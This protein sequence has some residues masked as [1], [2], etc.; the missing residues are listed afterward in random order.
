MAQPYEGDSSQQNQPGILGRNSADGVGVNGESDGGRGVAGF[1]KTWQGVYGFSDSN[2]GVVGESNGLDGVWGISNSKQHA[3]VSGHNGAG[4]LAGSFDGGVHVTGD[5]MV[6]GDVSLTNADIAEDFDV[7]NPALETGTV[8]CVGDDERLRPCSREYDTRVVGVVCGGGDFRPG[9]ILNRNR[10][11]AARVP[12]ALTGRAYC[13]A[14]A[15]SAPIRP[16]DQLTTSATVGHAMRAEPSRAPGAVV[17]KAL[18][19]LLNGRG[20][21]PVLVTLQ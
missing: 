6:D 9:I 17:G 12:V 7:A 3:G 15:T 1:S 2:A 10:T 14:D 20:L 19:S 13:M 5:L 4:G 8:L 11:E 16:G 21:I 18:R